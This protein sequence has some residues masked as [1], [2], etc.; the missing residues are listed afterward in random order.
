MTT[1]HVCCCISA[2]SADARLSSSE[3]Q[4]G[5]L[6]ECWTWIHISDALNCDHYGIFFWSGSIILTCFFY[7][8]DVASDHYQT[9]LTSLP[10]NIKIT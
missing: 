6:C 9:D 7:D 10:S 4:S 8:S 2:V 1:G 5:W 3:L